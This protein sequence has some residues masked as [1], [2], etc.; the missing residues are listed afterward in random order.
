MKG[1][2]GVDIQSTELSVGSTASVEN[3][4]EY[5]NDSRQFKART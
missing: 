4:C 1:A 5:E 2:S 3:N